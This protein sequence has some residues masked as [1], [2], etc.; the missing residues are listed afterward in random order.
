M[1]TLRLSL[2]IFN[3]L[4]MLALAACNLPNSPSQPKATQANQ[5]QP[6][7]QP[8]GVATAQNDPTVQPT[9]AS[10]SACA[11]TYYPSILG[12]TWTY[13]TTSTMAPSSVST[14]T[15]EKVSPTG[16]TTNDASSDVQVKVLWSCK[17]G[18][19]TMLNGATIAAK[20]MF[21]NA[22]TANSTGYLIP[23]DITAGGTWSE[24]LNILTSGTAGKTTT[25][26]QKN[27]TKI[28]CTSNGKES[29]QVKA[30]KFDA[31][32]VTCLFDVTT[33][34]DFNGQS[35]SGKPVNNQMTFTYWYAAGVGIVKS[36]ETGDISGT[37][38]LISYSIP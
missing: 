6:P 13:A 16:F 5:T 14:R 28:D 12:A 29:V 11:N 4:L 27:D 1:K 35:G 26:E 31:V 19:L 22:V 17:D 32:K 21:A 23:A 3:C 20:N 8:T 38:E 36:D 34:T 37:A 33:T 2:L 7:D 30:G 18:N 15:I 25:V 24:T 10:T 9:K